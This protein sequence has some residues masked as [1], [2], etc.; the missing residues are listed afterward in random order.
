MNRQT[1]SIKIIGGHG[2]GDC[3]LS[4]QCSQFT[5]ALTMVDLS[6]RQE[7]FDPLIYFSHGRLGVYI[8]RIDEKYSENN[9]VLKDPKLWAEATEGYPESYYVI[10]DLLFNNKYAFNFKKFNT[11]PS[12]ITKKRLFIN[13]YFV[14]PIK[15][16]YLGLISSTEGYT[17]PMIESL[18]I[19]LAKTF[20]DYE[21]NLPTLDRWANKDIKPLSLSDNLPINLYVDKNPNFLDSLKKLEESCYFIGTDNGPSHLAYHLGIPRILIDPQYNRLPWIARWREDINESIPFT[22]DV[23]DIISIVKANFE[24]P[25]T[26]LIPRTSCIYEVNWNNTLLL[27]KE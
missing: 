1:K 13:N 15:R 8:L 16:I 5:N 20:T 3:L 24:V 10:P 9:S 14:K 4:L 26:L 6:T 18:A 17:Y 7:V 27:K 12:L 25:A 19:R 2:L 21:I 11:N 23:G 22:S